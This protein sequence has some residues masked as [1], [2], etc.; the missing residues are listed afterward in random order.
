MR[1]IECP[2]FLCGRQRLQRSY[3]KYFYRIGGNQIL[4]KGT[5]GD[6]DS[7]RNL[8]KETGIILKEQKGNSGAEK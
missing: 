3:C 1:N 6:N 7:T 2:R 5:N 4:M 8:N